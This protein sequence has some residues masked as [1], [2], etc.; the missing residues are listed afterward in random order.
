MPG[1]I[2]TGGGPIEEVLARPLPIALPFIPFMGCLGGGAEDNLG[3]G[4]ATPF[5]GEV[6]APS[7]GLC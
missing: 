1:G 4:G 5:M 6:G 3:N 7:L 2:P